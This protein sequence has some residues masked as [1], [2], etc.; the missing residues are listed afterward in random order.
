MVK[1]KKQ[2]ITVFQKRQALAQY[3]PVIRLRSQRLSPLNTQLMHDSFLRNEKLVWERT[4]NCRV[5]DKK[6]GNYYIRLMR[7]VRANDVSGARVQSTKFDSIIKAENA[8]FQYRYSLE[9]KKTQNMLDKYVTNLK[10]SSLYDD[11]NETLQDSLVLPVPPPLPPSNPN[12][13]TTLSI[14]K[15]RSYAMS[16]NINANLKVASS[17]NSNNFPPNSSS[18]FSSDIL[19]EC[20]NK[21]Q[22]VVKNRDI[23][24]SAK[25]ARETMKKQSHRVRLIRYLSQFI[26]TDTCIKLLLGSDDPEILKTFSPFDKEHATLKARHVSDALTVMVDY[27]N[28]EKAIT[29]IECCNIAIKTITTK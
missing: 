3:A 2:T 21:I 19:H 18:I 25:N 7:R 26:T 29:W 13:S 14:A 15:R 17:R 12:P 28:R 22:R 27:C 4:S 1:R 20:A 9:S 11:A 16:S 5:I 24:R 23:R 8:A 6:N 10:L